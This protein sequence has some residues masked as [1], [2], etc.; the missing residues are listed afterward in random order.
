MR[1]K[2]GAYLSRL[3]SPIKTELGQRERGRIVWRGSGTIETAVC[4]FSI[5]QL[6]FKC[7]ERGIRSH[8]RF[9]VRFLLFP[10]CI[11]DKTY[12][13]CNERGIRFDV[14]FYVRFLLFPH[15]IMDKTYFKCNERG[16]RSHVRFYVYDFFYFLSAS[17]TKLEE[18]IKKRSLRLSKAGQLHKFNLEIT[19][20]LNMLQEKDSLVQID[21]IGQDTQTTES[22]VRKQEAVLL[23]LEALNKQ[24]EI[25]E[26]QA[27]D[28]QQ[29]FP[30]ELPYF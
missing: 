16:I 29:H 15:C 3:C 13:K 26:V 2:L 27:Q 4:M 24:I 11:M 9:Y 14:R 6:N 7:N 1:T 12:F 18:K 21:D 28:L 20:T 5:V 17:W 25:I 30:G 19:E 23:D 22:L 10:Q 8:V